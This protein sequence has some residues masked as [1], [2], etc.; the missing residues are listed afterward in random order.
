MTSP[1]RPAPLLPLLL[2]I[3][4]TPTALYYARLA[5]SMS[6]GVAVASFLIVAL[7]LRKA[8][9]RRGLTN[10]LQVAAGVAALLACHL[11]IAS[12]FGPI[13]IV[14][15][16]GSI[17]M[18]VLM[19]V[20]GHLL[21]NRLLA[22]PPRLLKKASTRCLGLLAV[23]GLFGIL[24]LLQP[25]AGWEKPAF[26]FTEPSH[27]ALAAAPFLVAASV[28]S[29]PLMRTVWLMV[30][31]AIGAILQNLTMIVACTLAALIT[32]RPLHI[33][34][35]LLLLVPVALSSD[36]GYF[37]VRLDFSEDNQNLS[38]L[39]FLQGWQMMDESLTVTHYV[40]RGF[41]QLGQ[42]DTDA[43]AAQL[44]YALLHDSL[45]LLDGGFNLAKIVSELG[46]IGIVLSLV[47]GRITW[48]AI[49]LLRL[50]VTAPR[51]AAKVPA[52]R[53]FAAAIILGYMVEMFVRGVGYFSP[54]GMLLTASLWVW[55]RTRAAARAPA[56]AAAPPRPL[57]AEPTAGL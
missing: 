32:L 11:V 48:S 33:V 38:S 12:A 44:I 13:D 31:V 56:I 54:S 28:G 34:A 43:P 30:F 21:A 41:Q 17:V 42:V 22:A 27:L 20:A 40:G 47:L 7:S 24:H 23:I 46:A 25:P 26:P 16:V 18:L 37:L 6:S 35:L 5:T 49:G 15:G 14:R 4:L 53:V 57:D 3:L 45:N 39:V 52:A 1:L 2:L 36:L 50:A 51:K 9:T 8:A 55:Y 19:I 29:R 10:A